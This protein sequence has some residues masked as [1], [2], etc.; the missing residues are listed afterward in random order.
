MSYSF[1]LFHGYISFQPESFPNLA[2][3]LPPAKISFALSHLGSGKLNMLGKVHQY[4]QAWA[5]I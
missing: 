3:E 1:L 2:L 5:E 4:H